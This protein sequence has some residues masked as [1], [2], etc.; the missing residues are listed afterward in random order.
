MYHMQQRYLSS[1]NSKAKNLSIVNFR[2][3]YE[4]FNLN[5]ISILCAVYAVDIYCHSEIINFEYIIGLYRH[6]NTNLV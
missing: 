1:S 4:I 2:A 5:V 3:K 6:F